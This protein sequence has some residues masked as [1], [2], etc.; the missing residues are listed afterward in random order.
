M[1]NVKNNVDSAYTISK[2]S[3]LEADNVCRD[4]ITYPRDAHH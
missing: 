4:F 2:N 3:I 1:Q